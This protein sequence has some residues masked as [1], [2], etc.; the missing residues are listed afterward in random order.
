M[1][2]EPM[3][4]GSVG[5]REGAERGKLRGG[6]RE[7]GAGKRKR[8]NEE[9]DVDAEAEAEH[10]GNQKKTVRRAKGPKEPN[11]LSVKKAKVKVLRTETGDS[12]TERR[13]S[14]GRSRVGKGLPGAE[15]RG[16]LQTVR[17]NGLEQEEE[18]AGSRRKRKR[19]HAAVGT[20][21]KEAETGVEEG[22]IISVLLPEEGL[23]AG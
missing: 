6:V 23:V 5:V 4:A 16:T 12:G 2:M 20:E 1:I 15:A 19:K 10:G 22:K 17:R 21:E 8:E 9:R 7:S 11:P 3:A 18:V 13:T 14:D